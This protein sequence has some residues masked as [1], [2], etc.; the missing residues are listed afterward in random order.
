[1]ITYKTIVKTYGIFYIRN[2]CYY[3][4]GNLIKLI[5][6]NYYC[7]N[8]YKSNNLREYMYLISG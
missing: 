2:G 1:M 6:Y 7:F 8:R 3:S 5:D 4:G